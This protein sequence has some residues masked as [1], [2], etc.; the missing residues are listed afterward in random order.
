LIYFDTHA[1]TALD[2]KDFRGYDKEALRLIEKDTD[3]RVSPMVVIE[4]DLLYEIGRLKDPAEAFLRDLERELGLHV[5][6]RPFAD[7]ARA[8]ASERWTRDPF[9]RIIVAQA[10]IA[11]AP[12][13]TRDTTIQSHYSKALG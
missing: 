7:V 6:D 12:L 1:V 13:I 10:R 5:C 3:F 2:S 9:D 8:A 11:K 4:M